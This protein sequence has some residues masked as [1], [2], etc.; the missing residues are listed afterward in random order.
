MHSKQQYSWGVYSIV[1]LKCMPFDGDD[2]KGEKKS[3][4]DL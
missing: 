2:E 4:L 1:D 3:C